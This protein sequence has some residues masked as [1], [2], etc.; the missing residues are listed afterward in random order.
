MHHVPGNSAQR[1]L[2]PATP[3]RVRL[4]GISADVDVNISLANGT[5]YERP[6]KV[7]PIIFAARL[8]VASKFEFEINAFR[9]L[10]SDDFISA[11]MAFLQTKIHTRGRSLQHDAQ[12]DGC[13]FILHI[14][15]LRRLHRLVKREYPVAM[16]RTLTR[17]LPREKGQAG[18]DL[19][20]FSC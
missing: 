5:L 6:G 8:C 14:H 20:H 7:W 15:R 12:R 17:P 18:S 1:Y 19:K 4:A 11:S 3:A 10:L 9:S 13:W 2:Q 16:L